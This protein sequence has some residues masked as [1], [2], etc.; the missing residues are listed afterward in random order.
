MSA[1]NNYSD[2][3]DDEDESLLFSSTDGLW[4]GDSGGPLMKISS[5]FTNPEVVGIAMALETCSNELLQNEYTVNIYTKVSSYVPWIQK[6]L[7]KFDHDANL[8]LDWKTAIAILIL[9][10]TL[11]LLFIYIWFKVVNKLDQED[12]FY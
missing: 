11:A 12:L 9:E 6:N 5:N 8:N 1:C 2:Q 7:E 4:F 3:V 10:L